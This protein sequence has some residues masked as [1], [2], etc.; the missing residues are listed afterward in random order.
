M[1]LPDQL[2]KFL[3]FQTSC[4]RLRQ[5]LQRAEST[6][7][8][9]AFY[10]RSIDD[11]SGIGAEIERCIRGGQVDDR[12]SSNLYDIRQKTAVSEQWQS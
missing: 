11:L 9:I 6:C 10:G 7:C 12:A 5:Y 1:L 2:E 4:K 3:Y 8:P